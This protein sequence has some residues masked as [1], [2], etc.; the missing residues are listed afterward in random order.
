MKLRVG[1]PW[2]SGAEY[3]RSLSGFGVNLLVRAIAPAVAFHRD[4]LGATVV[5]QDPDFAALR[6]GKAEMMLH[7]DHT[8]DSHPIRARLN[9][10]RGNGVELR[11]HHADPDAAEAAAR[12]AGYEILAPATDKRHGLREAYIV[13]PDGYVWVPDRPLDT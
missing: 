6:H 9:G 13:D 11:L 1:D 10:P 8:Y 7:A 4:V 3:G 5:Y 2:M 12:A